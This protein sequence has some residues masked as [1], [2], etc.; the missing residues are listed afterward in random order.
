MK[1]GLFRMFLISGI[2]LL[3]AA[4]SN[5]L[6][7]SGAGEGNLRITLNLPNQLVLKTSGRALALEGLQLYVEI[8]DIQD[9]E[10]YSDPDGNAQT[11]DSFFYQIGDGDGTWQD[12]SWGGHA[13]VQAAASG[14][15]EITLSFSDVPNDRDL[16]IRV[17]QDTDIGLIRNAMADTSSGYA[18]EWYP[19]SQTY[20]PGGNGPW[21]DMG[22]S[23]TQAQLVSGLVRIPIRP[24]ADS[25][26]TEIYNSTPASPPLLFVDSGNP[27]S[28]PF[29]GETRFTSVN[30]D[31]SADNTVNPGLLTG[32]RIV[33]NESAPLPGIVALYDSKG[34]LIPPSVVH[35]TTSAGMRTITSYSIV[36]AV[37][38]GGQNGSNTEY[39]IGSTILPGMDL[40]LGNPNY[41][42]FDVILRPMINGYFSS[43]YFASGDGSVSS[44]TVEWGWPDTGVYPPM[45]DKGDLEFQVL[46]W[47]GPGNLPPNIKDMGAILALNPEVIM[48]WG[49]ADNYFT[50]FGDGWDYEIPDIGLVPGIT[51]MPNDSD[52]YITVVLARLPG[53]TA[54]LIAASSG[55]Y[56]LPLQ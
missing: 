9:L 32:Y 28:E 19:L 24:N 33:M 1:S 56:I 42:S 23:L 40:S 25:W 13:V 45:T 22:T 6:W 35:N 29:P 44:H 14:T 17:I 26:N 27:P 4:C 54:F 53:G 7:Y 52:N 50:T 21:K 47:Y 39:F 12:T 20:Q 55:Q 10:Q 11:E 37:L 48:D 36:P 34:S 31:M 38:T 30:L 15:G 16:L 41:S 3:S 51:L 8:A 46:H 49:T 18:I 2:A 5:P 43:Y